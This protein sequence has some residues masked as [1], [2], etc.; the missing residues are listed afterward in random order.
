[1]DHDNSEEV[2]KVC[3]KLREKNTRRGSVLWGKQ[4]QFEGNK[5]GKN[6]FKESDNYDLML[7]L[8]VGIQCCVSAVNTLDMLSPP[9]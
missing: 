3:G 4:E 9:V 5:V 1:M 8:K 2:R 6:V 7:N